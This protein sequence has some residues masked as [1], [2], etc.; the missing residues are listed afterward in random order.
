MRRLI[1][2]TSLFW[3]AAAGAAAM[4]LLDP[5]QGRRRRSML[6]EQARRTERRFALRAR[7]F[8]QRLRGELT[9]RAEPLPLRRPRFEG[10]LG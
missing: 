6:S 8:A 2:A 7:E 3:G 4:F 1:S 10:P 9:G 5:D